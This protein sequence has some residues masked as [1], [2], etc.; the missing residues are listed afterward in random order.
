MIAVMVDINSLNGN[1][2]VHC[3]LYINVML[4]QNC[5][6]LI[7]IILINNGRKYCSFLKIENR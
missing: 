6:T 4:P 1:A 7:K 5:W 3:T 2:Y